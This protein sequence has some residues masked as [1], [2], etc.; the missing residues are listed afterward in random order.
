MTSEHSA[1]SRAAL[2]LVAVVVVVALIGVLPVVA[3]LL[4]APALAVICR[5]LQARL[6]SRLGAHGAALTILIAVWVLLV[7]PGAWLTALAAQQLPGALHEAQH[8]LAELRVRP[9]P[10]TDPLLHTN[11]DSLAAHF[12][13]TSV[14]WLSSAVGPALGAIA[15]GIVDL[16]VALLGL[17][18]LLVAG[19]EAWLAVRQ[20]LPFSIEGSDALRDVFGNVTRATLLGTLLSAALQGFS[21]GVGLRLVGNGAPAFW[22]IVAGFATL[23]P[24]VGNAIVW[25]PAVIVQLVQRDVRG[26]LLMLVFG[27]LLPSLLD[28]VVKTR[29]SRRVGHTHPMV[30][31]LG[32]LAGVRLVGAVGVLIGPSLIQTSLALIDLYDRE[33]GLPWAKAARPGPPYEQH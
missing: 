14:G 30:T 8:A 17:Y 6:S 13:S 15:H 21:I 3:G 24:V 19:D 26:V 2:F 18:F 32:A 12:G 25:L 5:P 33:Y 20:R 1:A 23:V 10:Q 4:A 31:L 28:R 9:A 7:V 16:S 29:I 22:G 27:K 11:V